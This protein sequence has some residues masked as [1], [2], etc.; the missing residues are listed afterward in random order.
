MTRDDVRRLILGTWRVMPE[1]VSAKTGL[2]IPGFGGT[3]HQ[4]LS[5]TGKCSVGP[6]GF[7][8][9]YEWAAI[10]AYKDFM[11]MD[12]NAFAKWPLATADQISEQMKKEWQA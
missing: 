7:T 8:E 9:V 2:R 1:G 5:V 10:S 6:S 11:I 12:V 4:C 3:V